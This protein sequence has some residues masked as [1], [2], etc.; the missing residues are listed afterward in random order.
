MIP[1]KVFDPH[2]KGQVYL[3]M[4]ASCTVAA[5]YQSSPE[6]FSSSIPLL[7]YIKFISASMGIGFLDAFITLAVCWNLG[8]L[9]RNYASMAAGILSLPFLT[10]AWLS[11]MNVQV[12]PFGP[13]NV[14]WITT[15]VL[16]AL[17]II[18]ILED[19]EFSGRGTKNTARST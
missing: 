13:L 12:Q 4:M 1:I 16:H 5:K 10:C 18:S 2:R 14:C 3:L 9:L 17:F 19:V 15:I 11:A 6:M 8:M 7:H